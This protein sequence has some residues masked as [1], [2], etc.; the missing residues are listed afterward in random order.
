MS[1]QFCQ[2]LFCGT[3]NTRLGSHLWRLKD[4]TTNKMKSAINAR[5]HRFVNVARQF[6]LYR[7]W[8]YGK[9]GYASSL[10]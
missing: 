1:T 4:V 9:N 2:R 3:V 10:K 6:R 5:V 7:A 8:M